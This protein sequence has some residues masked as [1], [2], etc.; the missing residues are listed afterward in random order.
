[1]ACLS[2]LSWILSI[3]Q[4]SFFTAISNS[5]GIYTA[6]YIFG[7]IN[8]IGAITTIIYLPETGG[9]NIE[10]IEDDLGKEKKDNENRIGY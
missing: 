6:F 1:M 9:K 5:A 4:L 7:A 10:Q 8:A 2:I 3:F